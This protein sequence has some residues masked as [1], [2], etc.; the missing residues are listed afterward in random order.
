[1]PTLLLITTMFVINIQK[2][3]SYKESESE[4]VCMHA[5]MGGACFIWERTNY[6]TVPQFVNDPLHTSR[7]EGENKDNFHVLLPTRCCC[8]YVYVES[9][10]C[11]EGICYASW[12]DFMSSGEFLAIW[13]TA[14]FSSRT[15][16]YGVIFLEFIWEDTFKLH[17]GSNVAWP[18]IKCVEYTTAQY[19][20]EEYICIK[21]KPV[22]NWEMCRS[23][24]VPL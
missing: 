1:M 15:V 9:G 16:L 3:N 2:I 7:S 14:S 10:Y 17:M 23:L 21:W 13:A 19:Y 18:L 20:F 5:C 8:L 24:D 12:L 22:W 11:F 6:F 4:C